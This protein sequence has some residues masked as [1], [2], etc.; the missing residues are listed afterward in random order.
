MPDSA[1]NGQ[2]QREFDMKSIQT[3]ADAVSKAIGENGTDRRFID[4]TRIPLICLSIT[5]IHASLE[6]LK[7][8]MKE[9]PNK[10]VSQEQFAPYKKALNTIAAALL[11][12]FVGG[13]TALLLK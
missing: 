5:G 2:E 6:E 3:L 11:L 1:I 4:I 13:L 9:A 8:M 10:Y 12:A 7:E